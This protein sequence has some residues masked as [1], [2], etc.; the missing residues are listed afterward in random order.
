MTI[1]A[2]RRAVAGLAIGL[3]IA[4]PA[5]RADGLPTVP[6]GFEVRLVAAVPA[7]QYPCQV[8]TAP[9][10]SLFVAEDPMDQVG[11]Y[12]ANDGRILR[13]R[14]GRGAPTTYAGGFRAVQGMAWREGALYVCHMPFLSVLR[15]ADGDGVAES[16]EDL[17]KDLG[18]TDNRG[19]NDHI[20]SGIQFG[21]DGWLY[22]SVG[23]KGVPGA[24]RPEDGQKVQLKGGGVLRC[25]PD[26]RELEIY[27][28]GTRNHLEANLD[29]ADRVFTY[30]NTDDGDGWWTRVTHHIDGCY[31]GYPYD[32]HD[33]PDRFLDRLAEYG[34]GSPCG[35]AFYRDDA[36]PEEWRGVGFWAEWGKGKV[37]A[38]RF[39]PKGASFEVAEM[40]D[41]ATGDD[42]D[43]PFRP[44]DLA[45]SYDG[46]TMYV[47]DWNMGGWG[48]ATEK[49]GRVYA[50]TH[51]RPEPR[52]RGHDAD[53]LDAQI[54]ALDHPAYT[55]R[56]RAQQAIARQGRDALPT[57]TRA[58][59]DPATPALA[60][61]HLIWALD[62]IARQTPEAAEPLIAQ[63]DSPVPDLRA[64]AAR[65][66]GQWRSP[67]AA[68]PLTKLV[69]DPDP[70]VRLQA[71]IALG[72]IGDPGSIA[73]ILPA[74]ADPERYVA[75]S[76]RVAL[77]RIGDWFAAA[78]GWKSDDPK[79]HAGL[80]AA[81]EGEYD[82]Q[83]VVQLVGLATLPEWPSAER[84]RA[85]AALAEVHR[86][87]PPWDGRWWGTR[88]TQGR[89]PAKTIAWEGTEWV[90]TTVRTALADPQPPVRLAAADATRSI[91]DRDALP[92]LRNRLAAEDDSTVKV[93]VV[94]AL[95]SLRDRDSL[96]ALTRLIGDPAAPDP[97]R[98]AAL[99]AVEAIGSDAAAVA[100]MAILTAPT[101]TVAS[102][103]RLIAA[104]GKFRDPAA[105]PALAERLAHADPAIRRA[106]AEA[107]AAIGLPRDLAGPLSARLDDPDL[108][109]RKAAIA[110]LGL[111]KIREAVPALVVAAQAEPT[112]FEAMRALAAMPDSRGLQVYLI[113][114]TDKNP[115]L[116]REAASAIGQ[117]REAAAPV[118]DQLAARRELAPSAVTELRKVYAA[119]R[120]I[121][122]WQAL[123]PFARDAG[124]DPEPPFSI[125]GA[126]D[127][128]ASYPGVG[129]KMVS[130]AP[131]KPAD[132]RGQ[133]ALER[134]YGGDNRAAFAY[135][136]IVSAAPRRA[137]V[138]VGSDDTLTLWV[139]GK[140]VYQHRGDRSFSHEADR[141]EIDLAA[142]TNRIV[143]RCGNGG[144]PWAFAV[145][146]SS[147]A[148]HAFLAAPAAGAFDPEAYRSAA[149]AAGSGDPGKGESLFRDPKGLA[150][151]KCHVVGGQGG[152]VGPDLSGVGAKYPREELIRSVLYPSSQIFSGYEPVVVA[153][154]DGRVLTGVVKSDTPQGLVI[155]DADAKRIEIPADQIDE[156]KASDVSLM[157]TGLAEGLTPADFADLIAYLESLK[158]TP[159]AR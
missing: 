13:F 152:A 148:D 78:A 88:P 109:A 69:A 157:P 52:P 153:T 126:P 121:A 7:V 61:R 125:D 57:V 144:G 128:G 28:S 66:L 100:V 154:A 120:P 130:W 23:D 117:I 114:L 31:Y 82:A 2:A 77:R 60:R 14:D 113:A 56:V 132:D 155:E 118:L 33:H 127:L 156:R 27:S 80:L 70:T 50:I 135:A 90:V 55:E 79:V 110:A 10:G 75:Y 151:A 112:R 67:L 81:M 104:L 142:G 92:A 131:A 34:G 143:A 149:L 129:D 136:E 20:V 25:R 30:D 94:R 74:L 95:G 159:P 102:Q 134:I 9:D 133:V 101:T 72:R 96:P 106:S 62:S 59:A 12:E 89:P 26:G 146:L 93:A 45:F 124:R 42:A 73:A 1:H 111:L 6:E 64:Q 41:F 105:I 83:A 140:E 3:A 19:L 137:E 145:A 115:D 39:R 119:V 36:W 21:I 123:G 107:L 8:A 32:Y 91:R 48:S 18:P 84:A 51:A 54:R 138:V 46:A 43:S 11:P 97:L 98:V 15:D 16:R 5:A 38:I 53:G 150:C 87:A 68:A 108:D 47:A 99:D 24:T 141:L 86:K 40:V 58:V 65:A 103:P 22:I 71:V 29:D 37:Q 76:A 147:P 49:V 139:N 63:L 122:D 17:F 158:E 44:I 85:L 4:V 35:A 116:R